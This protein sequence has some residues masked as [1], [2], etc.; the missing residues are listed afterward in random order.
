[1]TRLASGE[2]RLVA[3]IRQML[4]GFATE[5]LELL[6]TLPTMLRL[7]RPRHRAL[8]PDVIYEQYN[9]F[10]LAGALVAKRRSLPLLLEVNA[11]LAEER[12][13]F[14]GLQLESLARWAERF[15]WAPCHVGAAGH[16]CARRACARC[17]R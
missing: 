16:G 5:L 8:P 4:P 12:V 14:S 7:D 1:M 13:R 3:T 2:R 9:F 17:R 15:V 10:Y 6:Y 11:P